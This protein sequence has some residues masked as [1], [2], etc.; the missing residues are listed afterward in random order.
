[1]SLKSK[2]IAGVKWSALSIFTATLVQFITTVILARLLKPSDFGLMGMVMI[3]IGFAQTF[4]DMGFSNAIIRARNLEPGALSSFFWLNVLAGLFLIVFIILLRPAAAICFGRPDLSG[5]LGWGAGIF[6]FSPLNQIF[7]TILKK[8]L[9]FNTLSIVEIVGVLTYATTAIAFALRDFGVLSLILGQIFRGS[10]M[11]LMFI[12]VFRKTWRPRF[13]FRFRKIRR[14]LSFGAFQMGER[15]VN[16]VN[17]NIDYIIIGGFMGPEP[18]GYYTLAY[19]LVT[20]PLTRINPAISRVAFPALS[21]IQD[22]NPRLR[23]A[24]CKIVRYIA[25]ASF[26]LLTGLIVAAPEFIHLVYGARWEPSI[27]IIQILCVVGMLKSVGNPGGSILLSKGRADIGFYWNSITIFIVGAAM[28]IS[29]RWGIVGVA[30]GLTV[31]HV[32]LFFIFQPFVIRL[33][34]L[35]FIDFIKN[36]QLPFVCSLIMLIALFGMRIV[37]QD[38]DRTYLFACLVLSGGFL[39]IACVYFSSKEIFLDFK[40][41]LVGG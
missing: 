29:V 40:N 28:I 34:D 1:M 22:D 19:S 7:S 20:L 33:M 13:H 15:A 39:Y 16:Y 5:Y 8:E 3:I 30:I 18:L 17:A 14:H 32:P 21:K 6:L 31:I 36:L 10:A 25:L 38:I 23:N 26:P 11:S 35:K 37:L 12:A 2:A 4:T 41:M 9:R 27:L 24:Y